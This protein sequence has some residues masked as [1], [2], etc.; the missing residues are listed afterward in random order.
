MHIELLQIITEEED[1]VRDSIPREGPYISLVPP[2][3][4]WNTLGLDMIGAHN[5]NGAATWP[6]LISPQRY[7]WLRAAH[8]RLNQGTDFLQDLQSLMLRY[9]PRAETINPQGQ[10]YKPA[11][12]WANPPDT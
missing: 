10:K 3:S 1:P 6:T 8:A 9:H 11:N 7:E 12:P 5:S 4:P 2:T